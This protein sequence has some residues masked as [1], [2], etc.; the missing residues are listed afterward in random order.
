MLLVPVPD[1]TGKVGAGVLEPG[2]DFGS[3]VDRLLLSGHMWSASKTWDPEGLVSTLPAIGG[4]V[5][6]VLTGRWIA[7][8]RPRT[9]LTSAEGG[10]PPEGAL[11]TIAMIGAGG[12]CLV[13]GALLDAALMPINK[14][15]WTPSYAITM[16]GFGL[17]VFAAFY[18]LM[19]ASPVAA[20]RAVA[21]RVLQ[22]FTIYGMNA[23]F[24]FMLSGLIGKMLVFIKVPHEGGSVALKTA[25]YA[26][27]KAL[28]FAAAT[29][30]LFFAIAFDLLMFAVAFGMWKKRWFVKV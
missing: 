22:P 8:D 23:L 27:L 19:D 6:G 26:P 14:S 13:V 5:L 4:Q 29:T 12:G 28:P 3:W 17:V 11:K 15:L 2:R 24:V 10:R 20:V 21:T 16:T 7:S 9:V 30:S 1:L 25:L 18:W